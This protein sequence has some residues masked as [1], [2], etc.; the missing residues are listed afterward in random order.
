MRILCHKCLYIPPLSLE[1]QAPLRLRTRRLLLS[2]S[3]APYAASSLAPHGA[4]HAHR[5]LDCRTL[6]RPD[7]P[8]TSN[9]YLSRR[10]AESQEAVIAEGAAMGCAVSGAAGA[11]PLGA[12]AWLQHVE[13]AWP[14]W[15]PPPVGTSSC[16]PAAPGCTSSVSALLIA[17]ALQ[18]TLQSA[19]LVALSS[20]FEHSSTD[21]ASRCLIRAFCLVGEIKP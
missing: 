18:L 8:F 9:M 16:F 19:L 7:R 3:A 15:Q 20:S 14:V 13:N 6:L 10:A 2:T 5:S 17:V 1:M 21:H 12:L 11:P 4:V